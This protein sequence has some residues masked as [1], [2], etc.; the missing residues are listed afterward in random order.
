MVCDQNTISNIYLFDTRTQTYKLS[1]SYEYRVD[2]TKDKMLTFGTV[3]GGQV[4]LYAIAPNLN[5]YFSPSYSHVIDKFESAGT[6]PEVLTI[7]EDDYRHE[8]AAHMSYND[9]SADPDD[10]VIFNNY[11][12]YRDA[13]HIDENTK[14]DEVS[15][16]VRD[17]SGATIADGPL[18]LNDI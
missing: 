18:D 12:S 1:A 16:K 2:A 17:S 9:F 14:F 3:E 13:I 7:A 6:R 4:G 15:F 11:V 10:N 8:V 5:L